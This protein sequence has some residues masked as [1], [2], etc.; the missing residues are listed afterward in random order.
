MD[1]LDASCL[2][3]DD[4]MVHVLAGV[5]RD[6]DEVVKQLGETRSEHSELTAQVALLNH[7]L[8]A[9]RAELRDAETRLQEVHRLRREREQVDRALEAME[10]KLYRLGGV[11]TERDALLQE[12]E[13]ARSQREYMD[14]CEVAAVSAASEA[15]SLKDELGAMQERLRAQELDAEQRL[16]AQQEAHEAAMANQLAEAKAQ[17]EAALAEVNSMLDAA[18]NAAKLAAEKKERNEK[19]VRRVDHGNLF[20][21][22]PETILSIISQLCGA[23]SP[24]PLSFFN[25]CALFSNEFTGS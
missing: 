11:K 17:E 19:R 6:Q 1:H 13:A 5:E 22:F 7:M 2:L 20:S 4:T 12:V 18:L 8:D 15:M 25:P 14:H 10:D 3:R 9:S 16:R 23:P 21:F 24:P